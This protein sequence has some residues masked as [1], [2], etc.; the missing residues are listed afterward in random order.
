MQ[1]SIDCSAYL[2][3][4]LCTRLWLKRCIVLRGLRVFKCIPL[5]LRDS[6]LTVLEFRWLSKTHLLTAE[7]RGAWCLATIAFRALYI[8][9]YMYLL[10][11][12]LIGLWG[13][14][15]MCECL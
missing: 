3:T 14:V 15:E 4:F 5:H 7:D 11:Y 1:N 9:I 10:T 13:T 8:C 6:E 12:L 2:L